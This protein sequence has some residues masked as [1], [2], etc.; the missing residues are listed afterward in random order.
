MKNPIVRISLL[1]VTG[2][3]IAGILIYNDET[4][5]LNQNITVLVSIFALIISLI[6]AFKDDLFPFQLEILS[7]NLIAFGPS[8][9]GHNSIAIVFPM[10]FINEGHGTGIIESVVVKIEHQENR[11]KKLYTPIAEVDV[12]KLIQGKRR[13]NAENSKGGFA[14]F[15]LKGKQI[16]ER[17]FVF[18]QEEHSEKYPFNIWKPGAHKITIFIKDNH[19]KKFI[20]KFSFEQNFEQTMFADN[21]ASFL[22]N[23]DNEL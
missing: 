17:S 2:L 3:I 23:Y 22:M 4:A 18:A 10:S 8:P 15:P 21:S 13:L 6:S 20:N 7:G 9:E 16:I 19:T 12:E 1:V 5:S 11:E 14:F